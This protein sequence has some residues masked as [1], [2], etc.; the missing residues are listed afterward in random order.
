MSDIST[1]F[2][3][4]GIIIPIKESYSATSSIFLQVCFILC[5]VLAGC[6]TEPKFG[7]QVKA[8]LGTI[9]VNLGKSNKY[10]DKKNQLRDTQI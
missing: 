7:E 10:R 2:R 1:L 3:V 8:G 6:V 9:V 5:L 4:I